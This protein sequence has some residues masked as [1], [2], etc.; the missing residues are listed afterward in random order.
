MSRSRGLGRGLGALIPPTTAG[1]DE[2]DVGLIVLNPHQPR[3]QVSDES[4]RELVESIREHGVIQPLL[5]STSDSEGVYQLVA[6]E[7]R[8]RAARLAGLR[9]VPVVVKEAA[10]REL[11]ELALVE[12]LQRQDLSPLEEAQAYRR[13]ADDFGMT[14]EAIASRV[15]RSRTVVANTMRLLALSE[16]MQASLASGA[17]SEGHARALL[18]LADETARRQA[19]LQVVGRG[20]TVRRTEELVR[21]WPTGEAPGTG[22]RRRRREDPETAALEAKVR[23]VVGTKVELRRTA[24]GRGRLVLHFYSDEE[25]EALLARLGVSLG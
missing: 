21:R 7:R 22:R 25:L 17:I 5:V 9:R 24:S 10:S 15:G 1:V 14:Q 20:L 6:G 18:G 8:L 11:L 19:W 13:L 16:E 23:A 3:V 4:L 12:N 2:V